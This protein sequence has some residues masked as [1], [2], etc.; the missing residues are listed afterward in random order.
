MDFNIEKWADEYELGAAT[1][2]ALADKGFKTKLS[3]STL[4]ADLIHKEFENLLLAQRLLL[5]NA[6]E[7][8]KCKP[9]TE[10]DSHTTQ[11]AAASSASSHR[12]HGDHQSTQPQEKQYAKAHGSKENNV[13]NN[14]YNNRE[15][16]Y[17]KP[18]GTKENNVK[19]NSHDDIEIDEEEIVTEHDGNYDYIGAWNRRHNKDKDNR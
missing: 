4:S 11:Q 19:N 18:H 9:K 14:G 6:V 2:K 10:I 7:A 13:K 15:K 16:R 3:L 8:L 1:I 12:N 5:V 17:A